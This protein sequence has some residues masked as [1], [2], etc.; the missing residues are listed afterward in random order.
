VA[1]GTTKFD[2]QSKLLDVMLFDNMRLDK[3][4]G[5]RRLLD[6]ETFYG[7][8]PNE[9]EAENSVRRRFWGGLRRAGGPDT[10]F[11]APELAPDASGT[12]QAHQRP[13]PWSWIRHSRSFAR[14][15]RL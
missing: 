10:R 9:K 4:E 5:Q 3:I 14:R 13:P 1:R 8:V 15:G 7:Q 6:V 2:G 12:R 11:L